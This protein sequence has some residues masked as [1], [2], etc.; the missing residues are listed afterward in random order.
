MNPKTKWG[1]RDDDAERAQKRARG[2]DP[3]FRSVIRGT[4]ARPPVLSRCASIHHPRSPVP[5]N[6]HPCQ[7]GRQRRWG[8]I[9]RRGSRSSLRC[10]GVGVA[11]RPCV[12][13]WLIAEEQVP[14]LG[15][16]M[17]KAK[18]K[19]RG[20]E[21]PFQITP[22][23]QRRPR[24]HL[25][26]RLRPLRHRRDLLRPRPRQHP[27]PYPHQRP[28]AQLRARAPSRAACALQRSYWSPIPPMTQTIR[29]TSA[30]ESGGTRVRARTN[31]AV[32]MVAPEV[33]P[34]ANS[35][36]EYRLALVAPQ[37]APQGLP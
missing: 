11:P 26:L 8:G 36:E 3:H 37:L 19:K 28:P 4:H 18:A 6:P 31:R 22:A 2:G 13:S 17:V 20:S 21:K 32:M 16:V 9:D 34:I 33:R 29:R 25:P 24:P 5:V 15:V 10:R 7:R 27:C 12:L 35:G 14:N 1:R 30:S 23:C